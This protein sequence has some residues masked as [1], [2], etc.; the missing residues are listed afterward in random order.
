MVTLPPP[1]DRFVAAVNRGD[2]DGFLAL[3]PADAVVDDWGRRFAGHA[4]IRR[5][6]DREFVGAKGT[7]TPLA[8][9]GAGGEVTLDAD[10]KSN[11]YSGASRMVFRIDGGMVREMRILA[12]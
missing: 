5:W 9:A 6:S 8:V 1:I 11:F 2:T 12:P 7:L 4:A 10:W 3:M